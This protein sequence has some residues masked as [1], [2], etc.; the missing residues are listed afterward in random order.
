MQL[1]KYNTLVYAKNTDFGIYLKDTMI[2]EEEVLLPKKWVPSDLE[3]GDPMEVFLYKDSKG[4]LLA[5]TMKPKVTLGS[6]AR[7]K[8][9]AVTKIGAF[10]DWGLEKELLLPFAEQTRRVKEGEE[11]LI[12]LYTDKSSRLAATMKLYP[13]LSL[14]SPYTIGDEVTGTVYESSENFGVFVA[15]DDQ[16]SALIPRREISGKGPAV[17]GQV[18]A[19][20][21]RIHEDGKMDLDLRKKAYLQMDDDAQSLLSLLQESG[22]V[23][24]VSDRSDPEQIR[25]LTGMS[26]N[27]FK[28][29]VGRLYKEQK[30][31][32]E[33]NRIVLKK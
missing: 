7:L 14:R 16:Y 26:K 5:T 12:A 21:S 8:V 15:V 24:P 11:V 33:E 22:G 10:L 17:G 3:I 30:I 6:I 2:S 32:L 13:Y 31:D 28:R 25:E 27:A 20:I 4:R 18:T 19:R 23:L 1:G 9:T 29:A